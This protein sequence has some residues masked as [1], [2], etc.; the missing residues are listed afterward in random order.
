MKAV[1]Q[2]LQRAD[3]SQQEGRFKLQ[4]KCLFLQRRKCSVEKGKLATD[5]VYYCR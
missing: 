4:K 1:Y 2:L 3:A 5:H